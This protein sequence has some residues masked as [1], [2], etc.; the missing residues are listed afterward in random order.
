LT[1]AVSS[2]ID[3]LVRQRRAPRAGA[4]ITATSRPRTSFSRPAACAAWTTRPCVGDPG[5]RPRLHLQPLPLAGAVRERFLRGYRRHADPTLFLDSEPF[6]RIASGLRSAAYRIRERAGDLS[7]PLSEIA[8]L[9][10]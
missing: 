10:A 1:G 7:L 5:G 8:Q 4:S 9:V 3:A 2:R 6:W